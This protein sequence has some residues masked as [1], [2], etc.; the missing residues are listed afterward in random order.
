MLNTMPVS[1]CL[2][3]IAQPP[4]TAKNHHPIDHFRKNPFTTST[5]PST[6]QNTPEWDIVLCSDNLLSMKMCFSKE[7]FMLKFLVFCSFMILSDSLEFKY[8][9]NE[10]LE[11]VLNGFHN[12]TKN[13]RTNLY[14]IGRTK[15]GNKLWVLEITAAKQKL[16]I[17]HV[18]LIGNMHGNEAAGREILLHFIK[19][20]LCDVG[21]ATL[22]RREEVYNVGSNNINDTPDWGIQTSQQ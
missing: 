2:F 9:K 14:S 22:D 1:K 5:N 12:T 11:T 6:S 19:M 7:F 3:G 4:K 16:N 21:K 15:R 10:E 13:M 18:K 17:P 8:H 20:Y